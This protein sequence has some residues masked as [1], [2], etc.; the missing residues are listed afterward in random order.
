MAGE[1][2]ETAAEPQTRNPVMQAQEL[3]AKPDNEH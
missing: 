2:E 1:R 3:L